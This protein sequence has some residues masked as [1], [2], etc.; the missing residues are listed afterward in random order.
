LGVVY[1]R[2]AA[3]ARAPPRASPTPPADQPTTARQAAPGDAEPVPS[4]PRHAHAD[5]A[6]GRVGAG[7][8]RLAAGRG[9]LAGPAT[10]RA[11]RSWPGWLRALAPIL[12]V[13]ALLLGVLGIGLRQEADAQHTARAA[14][15]AQNR[16]VAAAFNDSAST[17]LEPGRLVPLVSAAPWTF[18]KPAVDQEILRRF[19]ASAVGGPDT[20]LLLMSPTGQV[21]SALPA[22]A[23]APIDTSGPQWRAAVAGRAQWTPVIADSN[24][25][26]RVYALEPVIRADG[27]AAV[28]VI[29]R[30]AHHGL[31]TVIF[32]SLAALGSL[33]L[34]DQNGRVGF[35]SDDRFIGRHVVDPAVLSRLPAEGDVTAVHS[36][37]PGL[38][39]FAV[40]MDGIPGYY[41]LLQRSRLAVFDDLGS[42]LPGLGLLLGMVA[43]TLAAVAAS[44][45]RRRRT[46]RRDVDR[47]EALLRGAHDIVA[48][49]TPDCRISVVGPSV[50]RLLG[51]RP[52]DWAGHD[53]A[54][55]AHP[56]DAAR[57]RAFVLSMAG[58]PA[59][60]SSGPDGPPAAGQPVAGGPAPTG[61]A[62]GAP[63]ASPVPASLQDVRIRAADGRHRWFDVTASRLTAVTG[64]TPSD[65]LLTCHDIGERKVLQDE[66]T[67]AAYRDPLTGLPNRAAFARCLDEAAQCLARRHAERPG[68]PGPD[69][70]GGPG[71]CVDAATG[72]GAPEPGAG[73]FGVLFVDLDH[74]K[75][76][77][78]TYGHGTGDEVL[79][80]VAPRLEAAV[81]AGDTVARLGGDEF[82]ILVADTDKDE[83]LELTERVLATLRQP[84][85]TKAA[86]L[87]VSAT[88]GAA[89]SSAYP[90]PLRTVRA[91]D[92]AMYDA[93]RRGRGSVVLA[94]SDRRVPFVPALVPPSDRDPPA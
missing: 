82:A 11:R 6:R 23:K 44:D 54:D 2:L 50:T 84:L 63:K 77:N 22:T 39:S 33:E 71:V 74:F 29:G 37:D 79:E 46:V 78:D 69:G 14:A 89:L 58:R 1:K 48:V 86:V 93:K 36:A 38:I 75:P 57:L 88:I 9:E 60:A 27:T 7:R 19:A 70:P 16:A 8:G 49:A 61:E 85:R 18:T 15:L 42:S 67:A 34:V 59:P 43:F 32:Q 51:Q 64:P 91:A 92:L 24:G 12:A 4:A 47:F 52:T 55:L 73:S 10:G 76:I 68:R 30:S 41:T 26:E 83:L 20:D 13:A 94:R 21:L 45:E 56:E 65:V 28:L 31:P 62:P 90:D 80:I 17:I 87:T 40:P 81:R 5:G 3:A 25:T 72:P 53:V 66:L 35:G